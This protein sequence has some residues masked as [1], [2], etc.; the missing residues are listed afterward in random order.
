MRVLFLQLLV[1]LVVAVHGWAPASHVR[2]P[3]SFLGSSTIHSSS[4]TEPPTDD[5]DDWYA[6]FDPSEY[7]HL[8]NTNR[9]NRG[10]SSASGGG[11]GNHDYTRDTQA[12]NS[13]REC[14]NSRIV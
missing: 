3:T 6:D 8:D 4:S 12:D 10:S 7:E 14:G 9:N 13:N 11:G 1:L 2:A 5:Y